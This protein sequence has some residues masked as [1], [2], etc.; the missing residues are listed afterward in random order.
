MG[1]LLFPSIMSSG[2][3]DRETV[4]RWKIML[5]N[6]LLIATFWKD[7]TAFSTLPSN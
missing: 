6:L 4:L 7:D 1:I 2:G 5:P 3:H